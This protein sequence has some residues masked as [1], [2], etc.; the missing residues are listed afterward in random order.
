VASGLRALLRGPVAVQPAA[1]DQRPQPLL[2]DREQRGHDRGDHDLA[3]A[4]HLF[5]GW[6]GPPVA[7]RVEFGGPAQRRPPF[8]AD[9]PAEL[10]GQSEQHPLAQRLGGD[11]GGVDPAL[12]VRRAEQP[13]DHVV[14]REHRQQRDDVG[15][16]LVER[17]LVGQ[18]GLDVAGRSPS[19][20]A[21]VV[22][23]ATTS[24]DRQV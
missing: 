19:R 24:C 21:C 1:V 5:E 4:V 10:V 13:A 9:R 15:E 17:A 11:R 2:P 22:S 3:A 20:I 7:V 18:P 23:C 6:V 12:A 14:D 8:T 16:R